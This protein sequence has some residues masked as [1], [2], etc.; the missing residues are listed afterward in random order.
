MTV[1]QVARA[2]QAAQRKLVEAGTPG[3]VAA[4]RRMADA[5][6]ARAD[7][8]LA[9]NA[10]DVADGAAS[11]AAGELAAATAKRLG[12]SRARLGELSQGLRE[13]AAVDEPVGR[14]LRATEL[15]EG[16]VLR[17]VT[18]P[19]GVILVVFEA[20]PDALPQIAGLALR[21]GNAVVL[22]GGREAQRSN[23]ALH[24][25]LTEALAPDLPGALIGLVHERADVDALLALDDVFALVVP[26]GSNA[27][28]RSIQA[29]TRIPVLGHADGVCHVYVDAAA[30]LAMACKIVHDAKTDYPA[31]CNAL[32]TLLVHRQLLRDGRLVP[33]LASLGGVTLYAHP[34]QAAELALPPAADLHLEHGDLAATVVLVDDVDAAIDHVHRHGSA[35]TDAIVTEDP[36]VARRWLDRVDSA[37]VFWNASTR[38][39]DGWRFGL[40]AE[41]G[42]STSRLHAR[43]PVGVDGLLTTRWIL[44]GHG[45]TV[46]ETKTGAVRFTHRRV[47]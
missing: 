31:A 7:E 1:E 5:L 6:E 28:V 36:T 10:L 29:R 26:R 23:T 37:C 18:S 35:H 21:A 2:A 32:E 47:G 38:F 12:L 8:I 33:L 4:L 15:A 22:K 14:V 45:Q 11:V 42:I 20:R 40:G 19:L 3:R 39:A 34:D 43:G 30:D 17:Q 24:R 13:L 46:G 41:V 25:V 44:E 9:A 16:L 27:L